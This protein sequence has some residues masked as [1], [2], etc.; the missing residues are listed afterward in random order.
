MLPARLRPTFSAVLALACA[1]GADAQLAAYDDAADARRALAEAQSSGAAARTRAEQLEAEAAGA[2]QAVEHTVREAAAVAA[3]I[4]QDEAE[5]AAAEARIRLIEVQRAKLRASLAERQRPLVRLTAALQRLSRRPL[6]I[7]LLRPGSVADAVH[8]RALIETMVPEVRKRTASL[9]AEI[10]R[11]HALQEQAR[12]AQTALRA[13]ERELSAR[14]QALASLETRQRLA[15]RDVSGSADREAERALALAEQARDLGALA[16]TLGEADSLREQLAA[17]PGPV[18]RPDRLDDGPGE[19]VDTPLP[20]PTAPRHY[21][22]PAAGRLVAG[23]GDP[24]QAM[25][26]RGISLAVRPGAQVVAPGPGRVAFAGPYRGYGEIVIIAHEGKWTS[27]VTG[28]AR[29]DTRV[30]D[31][32][33]SGSPIGI[34]G[35]SRPL[36]GLELRRA[37]SP[38]NPLEFIGRN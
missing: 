12:A 7:A 25:T 22:L 36:L 18:L 20:E 33:V 17:L 10:A 1:G 13:Q 4:Q 23:F 35:P 6:A 2:T 28:L 38:V 16:D 37:G 31:T 30:G 29:L 34:A 14:R 3:R 32:L 9:R 27:L 11:G 21:A 19:A 15:A 26:M 8:T 5:M 24:A